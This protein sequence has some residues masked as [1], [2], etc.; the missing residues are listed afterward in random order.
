MLGHNERKKKKG[1]DQ[2]AKN[3]IRCEQITLV[4]SFCG[5]GFQKIQ[6]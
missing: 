2:V 5:K 6:R 3:R 1:I 4:L